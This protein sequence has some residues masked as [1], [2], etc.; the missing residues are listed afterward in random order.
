MRGKICPAV[1]SGCALILASVLLLLAQPIRAQNMIQIVSEEVSVNFPYSVDF[2]LSAHSA[3]SPITSIRLFWQ[4]SPED[5]FTVR[6]LDVTPAQTVSVAVPLNALFLDLP[7]FA[8]IAYRWQIRDEQGHE[9]MTDTRVVEYQDTRSDWQELNNEHFR[10]LWYG[11]DEVFADELFQIVEEAY[12]RLERAFGVELEQQPTVVIYPDRQVF[13]EFQMSL[14][15]VFNVIGRYF[16]G[17]NIT[18]NLVSP[19]MP[20]AVY[21]ETLAHELS[22]L[23]SD[24]FYLGFTSL[25]L[26]LEEG[27]ATY[28][29]M[30]NRVGN[31]ARVRQAASTGNLVAFVDLPGAIRH[32]DI[33]ITNLAY[34]EGATV[35]E[36][37]VET[38]GEQGL[39]D[40][41]GAFRRTSSVD[42]ATSAVFE[43]SLVEFELGWRAW[44]GF[45]VDE[46]PQPVPTPTLVPFDF[47]TPAFMPAGGS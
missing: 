41:L 10:M 36:Y 27:L 13:A 3:E 21:A 44:L 45:P 42:D 16:P 34:A 38:W 7:P 15:N 33:N 23:Y 32:P 17:H 8:Q 4:A 40:F 12:F 25:P 46:V 20:R 1:L 18:V 22:H 24:N 11:Y 6:V 29:E 37:V 19:D 43:L 35:I 30:S 28:N 26:W 31:L 14:G 39:I 9:L 2:D 5:A 47:P